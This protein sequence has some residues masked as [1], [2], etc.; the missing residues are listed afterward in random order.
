MS[1][2]NNNII[3]EDYYNNNLNFYE[4]N[5]IDK[6]NMMNYKLQ[7]DLM[8]FDNKPNNYHYLNKDFDNKNYYT[9]NND[10]DIKSKEDYN[11]QYDNYY[12]IK[13]RE[14]EVD[15]RYDYIPEIDKFKDQSKYSLNQNTL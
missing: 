11:S 7:R 13:S 1:R 5:N 6:M 2:T 10:Y 8:N 12:D 15:R 9:D 14:G 4:K 3:N